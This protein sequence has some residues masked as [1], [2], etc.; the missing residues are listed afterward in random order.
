MMRRLA[1]ALLV[2]GPTIIQTAF[3]AEKPVLGAWGVETQQISSTLRPGDDFY[4]YVNEGWLKTAAPP[5]GLPYASS[6]VD[7]FQRTQGQLQK[8]IDGIIASTPAPGSD[9]AQIAALYRSYMGLAGRNERGLSPVKSDLDAISAIKTHEDAARLQAQSFFKSPIDMGVVIDSKRP[10]RYVITVA[11]AGLGLPSREYYLTAGEPFASHRAGYLAYIADTLKRAG[12]ADGENRAKAILAFETKIAEAQ[13]TAAEQRDPVK[14]Y[15]LMPIA[16]L[17]TY[18]AAFPWEAYFDA[19]G[20]GQP[21][22]VVLQTDTAIRKSVEIF[23]AT[24]IETIKSYLAFHIVDEFAPF[25]TEELEQANFTFYNTRLQGISEQQPIEKRAQTFV[26]ATFGENLGRAYT[27]SYFPAEYRAKMDRMIANIRAAFGKRLEANPWMDEATRKAALV[28]LAAIVKHVGYPDRWRDW[29]SVFFDPADPVG[30]RR[31][32]VAFQRTDAIAML[33]EKRREWQWGSP[34]TEINAGYSPKMNSITFP[35]GIL[36]PPFFDPNADDAVNYGAIGAVIGHEL[37]HAFD[38]EGSQSDE[39]GALRNWW[40]DA[41]RAEFSKRTAVLVQQFDAYVPLPGVHV[42]G[43]LTLGENIGDLGGITIAYEAY[44]IFVDQEQGGK[45]PVID[46][47]TGDQ[48]FFLSWGQ[49]WRGFTT[50][51]M[52]RQNLLSDPHSPHEF[53][54]NGSLRNV[55]AWYAAFGVKEGDKLYLPPDKRVRIW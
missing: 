42:N 49:L 13:W 19:G 23:K 18:A 33:G 11:Q 38:D 29:S 36:Q 31:K 26:T 40:S 10:E 37:G 6:F 48:R 24:D 15:R 41:S 52:A 55:D 12:M 32:A 28:K 50:S 2:V 53:R 47:F 35:A 14:S 21:G 27:K 1:L 30:N 20:F 44:R 4:R 9:E 45:A 39:K 17:S 43:E 54:V 34:A 3:A 46:G 51:D 25:L 16:E 22:E 7:A 8:L 5:P